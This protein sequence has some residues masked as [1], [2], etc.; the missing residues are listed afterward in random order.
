MKAR[1]FRA[2]A[3]LRH[4]ARGVTILVV[5]VLLT[6]MLL[7][8][9]ALARMTQASVLSS[10][11]VAFRDA[12]LQASEVGLNTAFGRVVGI[13]ATAENNNIAGWYWSSVLPRDP[14]TGLP[15]VDW[16]AA[17]EVNVGSYSVR[18]VA[19]RVCQVN[20]VNDPL[21]ECLVKAK[22]VTTSAVD[23]DDKLESPNSRQYRV[24]VRV[25]GP[26]NTTTFIQSLITKG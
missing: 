13:A 20:V 1:A 17:P 5:L 22:S 23:L 25:I 18:Y 9:M 21:R 7:A 19:E 3:P 8:G 16:E 12:S 11:N 2:T 26:K 4:P 15:V 6:V 10:G 14:V 24:T